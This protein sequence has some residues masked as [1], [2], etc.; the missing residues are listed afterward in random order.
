MSRS[1]RKVASDVS[2]GHLNEFGDKGGGH[3]PEEDVV[4]NTLAYRPAT[5]EARVNTC[6]VQVDSDFSVTEKYR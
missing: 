3:K 4:F 2:L 1:R 5:L 6:G